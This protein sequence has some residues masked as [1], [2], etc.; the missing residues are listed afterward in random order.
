M[1]AFI[2]FGLQDSQPDNQY[3]PNPKAL[4]AGGAYPQMP[5]PPAPQF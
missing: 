2:I 4:G 1:I 3:G 5:P